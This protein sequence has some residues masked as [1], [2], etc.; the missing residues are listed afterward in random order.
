LDLFDLPIYGPTPEE[1]RQVVEEEGS[2][3]LKTLDTV[4]IGWDANLQ[5]NIDDAI[6]D[7]KT[8]AK[9]VAKSLRAVFE[10]LLSAKF[11]EVIMDELFFRFAMIV[12]QLIDMELEPLEYT[13]V[14]VSMTK[15]C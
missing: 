12:A 5:E 13:N 15:D 9:L 3:T 11:G 8:R 2:F 6:V 10:P 14:I 7:S 1:V 4:R